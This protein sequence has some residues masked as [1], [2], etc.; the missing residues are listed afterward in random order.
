MQHLVKFFVSEAIAKA[1]NAHSELIASTF[2]RKFKV[3]Q[4]SVT[5]IAMA[6][7]GSNQ[8][9][10]EVVYPVIHTTEMEHAARDAW[11]ITANIITGDVTEL[12]FDREP[13]IWFTVGSKA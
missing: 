9:I 5:C 7:P 12:V 6:V 1:I 11:V 13:D 4:S 8:R 3:P 10:I 2:A